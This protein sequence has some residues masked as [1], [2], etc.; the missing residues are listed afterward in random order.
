MTTTD[1]FEEFEFR[2]L[3][4]GLGF[5]RQNEKKAAAAPAAFEFKG[6]LPE[7]EMPLSSRAGLEKTSDPAHRACPRRSSA[8]I[9]SIQ[10]RGD[11]PRLHRQL[12][13]R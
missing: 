6:Q 12:A 4:E 11:G 7:I 2:P 5:H 8:R 9:E 3:T 10:N 13:N 1:P